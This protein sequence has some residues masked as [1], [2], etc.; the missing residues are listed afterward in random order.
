MEERLKKYHNSWRET[1]FRTFFSNDT[2]L[3]NDLTNYCESENNFALCSNR[4]TI[5]QKTDIWRYIKIY[6]NGGIYSDIDIGIKESKVLADLC[7]QC[8]LVIFCESPTFINEPFKYI[9]HIIKFF[10]GMN[11]HSRLYQYRQSIFYA[12]KFH[13]VFDLLL[14][15]ITAHNIL[16]YSN[17][18]IEPNLTFELTGPGIFTDNVQLFLNNPDTCVIEYNDGLDIIDYHQMGSLK[19]GIQYK[20]FKIMINF[21]LIFFT[22]RRYFYFVPKYAQFY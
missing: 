11:D 9:L 2:L 14:S 19:H 1:G 10:T 3:Y 16:Q 20:N 12:S 18:F 21:F 5:I 22:I 7:T 15:Q 8:N 17:T 4:F 13:P 6:Q